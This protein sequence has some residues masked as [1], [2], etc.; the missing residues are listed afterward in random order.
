MS[1]IKLNDEIVCVENVGRENELTMN[2][3]YTVLD[4]DYS[5]FKI[6]GT[7]LVSIKNDEGDICDYGG[8]R[9]RTI[10]KKGA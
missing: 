10:K 9:F 4:T 1:K 2:K 3:S 8:V 7:F 5:D 6:D